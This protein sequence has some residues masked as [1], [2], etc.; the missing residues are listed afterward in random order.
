MKKMSLLIASLMFVGS[1]SFAADAENKAETTT[2]HSKNPITGSETTTKKTKKKMKG[3]H[4]S[5]EMTTKEKTKTD[6]DG[7]KKTTTETETTHE[8]K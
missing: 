8:A 4:A 7:A 3:D 5:S 6:S 2:D 1:A